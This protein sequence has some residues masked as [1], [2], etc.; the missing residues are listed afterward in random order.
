MAISL[1]KCFL[2]GMI[3]SLR[4][5]EFL[6]ATMVS[7]TNTLSLCSEAGDCFTGHGDWWFGPFLRLHSVELATL[8]QPVGQPRHQVHAPLANP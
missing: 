6:A 2:V 1:C 7:E 5:F 3:E 4:V 8:V